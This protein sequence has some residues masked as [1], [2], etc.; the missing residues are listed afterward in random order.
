ME[1]EISLPFHVPVLS[2]TNPIYGLILFVKDLQVGSN[3][4]VCPGHI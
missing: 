2:Q 3:M 4:T 1:P